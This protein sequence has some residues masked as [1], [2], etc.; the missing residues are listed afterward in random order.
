MNVGVW[1]QDSRE[2]QWKKMMHNPQG[3]DVIVTT[4]EVLPLSLVTYEVLPPPTG[5]DLR[6]TPRLRVVPVG[7]LLDSRATT[8]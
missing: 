7:T 8:L 3:V 5:S 1:A 2:V 6:G 4:Y